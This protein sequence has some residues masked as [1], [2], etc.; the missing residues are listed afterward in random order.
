MS[1]ANLR[2]LGPDV[3][4]IYDKNDYPVRLSRDGSGFIVIALSEPL[5]AILQH[6]EVKSLGIGDLLILQ[7]SVDCC[8]LTKA[9]SDELT[10]KADAILPP[11]GSDK[12]KSVK[13][14]PSDSLRRFLSPSSR[15]NDYKDFEDLPAVPPEQFQAATIICVEV[16]EILKG[17]IGEFFP[18]SLHLEIDDSSRKHITAI[19]EQLAR[20][21]DTGSEM[22]A[23]RVSRLTELVLIEA[24]DLF[25]SDHPL[26]EQYLKGAS[27]L[28]IRNVLKAVHAEP[29]YAWTVTELASVANMSRSLF[30]ER[31]RNSMNETPLNY[32]RQCRIQKAKVL[33]AESSVPLVQV[34]QECGY[35][36]QSAFIKAFL[37]LTG[38]SP[39]EWRTR[40]K[41]TQTTAHSDKKVQRRHSEL[42]RQTSNPGLPR[43]P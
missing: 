36:S 28:R 5:Y 9:A 11:K 30:A 35:S 4:A 1:Y 19:A 16:C 18:Q 21:T 29:Q 34:A 32:V 41:P 25:L 17:G 24:I 22:D 33:L 15:N 43:H 7:E 23:A 10:K 13:D 12:P 20:F 27:D 39:K 8:L 26:R 2:V 38:D 6:G 3:T 31:F 14:L 42:S 37:K 40:Y